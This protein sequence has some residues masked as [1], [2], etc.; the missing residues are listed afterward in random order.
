MI[1]YNLPFPEYLDREGVSKS[2]LVSF[3]KAPILSTVA[4]EETAAMRLGSL[5]HC[6]ILEPDQLAVRYAVS[7][8]GR[9]G[10]KEWKFAQEE[11]AAAGQTIVKM[12]DYVSASL[13]ADAI[14]RH[15]TCSDLLS[16]AS[17]EVS[18]FWDDPSGLPAK[19]RLDALNLRLGVALDIKTTSDAGPTEF[20][21]SCARYRYHWQHYW[22]M[23]GAVANELDL[24][25]F[26]FIAI[27]TTP[28]YLI[29][30][31]E[32]DKRWVNLAGWSIKRILPE[33]RQ[34]LDSGIWPGL[35]PGI[36]QINLPV[37]CES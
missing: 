12:G 37:W 25:A 8:A 15:K 26:L 13:I 23:S 3:A 1:A 16:D 20:A 18:L 32:I 21:R 33:Y 24:T 19:A 35:D 2:K 31:Y 5:V 22:Y 30:I 7:D 17:T 4:A 14:A 9:R 29:G 27:E 28:P 11:A 6:A 10:T 34:C 36:V